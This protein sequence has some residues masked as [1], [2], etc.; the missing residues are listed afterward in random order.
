MVTRS[1]V[2]TS[3]SS[4][5][6][7]GEAPALASPVTLL[8]RARSSSVVLPIALTTTTTSLPARLARTTLSATW[9]ILSTSATEEP[10][11]F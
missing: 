7:A 9:P 10:P 2:E 11:Y 4:S 8:A 1:P 6:R 3:M 5:R